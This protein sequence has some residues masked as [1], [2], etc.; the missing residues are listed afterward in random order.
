VPG[1]ELSI[2]AS[3]LAS[4]AILLAALL[5]AAWL[6]RRLRTGRFG[7]GQKNSTAITIIATRALGPGTA[8]LIVEAQGQQFLIA[9]ARAGITAL[10]RLDSP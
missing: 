10:G 3:S 7:A 4:L 2:I 9:S 6:A 1:S 5:G 8:L